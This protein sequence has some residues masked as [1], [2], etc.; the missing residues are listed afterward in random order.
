MAYIKQVDP[1]EAEGALARVY[2]AASQRTG[3]VPGVIK[4]QS[5]DPRSLQ[6]MMQLYIGLMKSDNALAPARRELLAAV[7]S[8]VN[9][10][11]Y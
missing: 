5:L 11:F 6:A 3:T 8:N 4:V 10:C 1:S 9:E 2:D 7:V